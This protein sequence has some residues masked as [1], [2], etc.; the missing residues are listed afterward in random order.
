MELRVTGISLF[1]P[2]GQGDAGFIA[3]DLPEILLPMVLS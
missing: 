3:R 2:A 1:A